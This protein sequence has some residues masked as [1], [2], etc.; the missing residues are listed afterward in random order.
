VKRILDMFGVGLGLVALGPIIA[1]LSLLVRL[2]LG[3]PIFFVQSRPGRGERIFCLV[4]FRTMTS[5]RDADGTLLA[6]RETPY[7]VRGHSSVTRAWTSCRTAG[8]CSKAICHS[9]VRA[10]L[11]RST[12]RVTASAKRRRHNVRPGITGWAQINGRNALTWEE[13]ASP[14]HMVCG[15]LEL[16]AGFVHLGEYTSPCLEAR[17][18]FSDRSCNDAGVHGY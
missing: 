11:L 5:A 17:R 6:G 1:L 8:T 15:Q 12:C 16:P 4:K 2:R 9:S 18:N 7:F 10:P 14:R 3:S 13:K